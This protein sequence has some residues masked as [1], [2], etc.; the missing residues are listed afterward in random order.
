MDDRLN[1]LLTLLSG[2]I[3][4]LP[5]G[6]GREAMNSPDPMNMWAGLQQLLGSSGAMKDPRSLRI[7]QTGTEA[8]KQSTGTPNNM[9]MIM[10]LIQALL[11]NQPRMR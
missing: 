6:P 3:A 4:T 7:M 11:A 9:D 5:K 8:A 10:S 2:D 1:R